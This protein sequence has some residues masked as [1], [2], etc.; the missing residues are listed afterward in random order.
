MENKEQILKILKLVEDGKLT[1]EEAEEIITAM[2]EA[3]ADET[4]EP[5]EPIETDEAYYDRLAAEV[6]ANEAEYDRLADE[7]E[8]MKEQA[9][10]AAEQARQRARGA[11][12]LAGF[13]QER[14]QRGLSGLSGLGETISRTVQN[15]IKTSDGIHI[16]TSS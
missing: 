13:I 3:E 10:Q 14:V 4:I 6:E 15:A 5:I 11:Q 16:S 2:K 1:P 9:K 8:K 12:D 7:A